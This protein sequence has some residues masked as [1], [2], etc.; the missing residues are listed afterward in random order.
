MS[1]LRKFFV[2]HDPTRDEQ[3]AF[4]R[5]ALVAMEIGAK[6]HLFSSIYSD[7][8]AQDDKPAEVMRLIDNQKQQLA[9]LLAPLAEQGIEVSHEVEWDQDWQHAAVRASIHHGADIVFKS[10]FTH[11][12]TQRRIRQTSDWTLIRECLCP[13]LLVKDTSINEPSRIL[14]AVDILAKAGS[15]EKLNKQIIDLG[16][17]MKGS[18]RTDVHLVNAF[19]DFRG[20]PERQALIESSGIESDNI[21][22]KMGA[23]DKVIIDTAKNINANL[24]IIGNSGRSGLSAIVHGNTIEKV[25]DKLECNVLSMP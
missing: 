25:L 21:H 3:P 2:V 22:I 11:S 4:E 7:F 17:E 16:K 12:H 10:S 19:Q 13:V 9:I 6:L 14:A 5:A 20:I 1:E 15:Y 24:V 23:P 8:S 18:D